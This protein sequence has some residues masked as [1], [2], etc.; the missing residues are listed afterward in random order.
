V[1]EREHMEH[2]GT[3]RKDNIKRIIKKE[4]GMV[5]TAL[6]LPTIGT[7]FGLL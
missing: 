7:N 4:N 5:W 1:K 3:D 6:I 2:P